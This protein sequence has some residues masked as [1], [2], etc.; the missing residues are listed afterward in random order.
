L[1][2]LASVG[3]KNVDLPARGSITGRRS[4]QDYYAF[5][6]NT[7]VSR[8]LNVQYRMNSKIMDWSSQAMYGGNVKAHPSVANHTLADLAVG[9][10][11][12]AVM[13][14]M[15]PSSSLG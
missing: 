9:P 14:V 13:A 3:F 1:A 11:C 5:I 4:L 2:W 7:D 6:G 15:G 10:L 12:V 8:M